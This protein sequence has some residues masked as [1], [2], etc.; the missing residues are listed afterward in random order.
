MEVVDYER[1]GSAKA[2]REL[3]GRGGMTN[4]EEGACEN[5]EGRRAP[6][7]SDQNRLWTALK[8]LYGTVSTRLLALKLCS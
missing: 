2:S 3:L 1:V 6:R 8:L 4:L 5:L 7:G